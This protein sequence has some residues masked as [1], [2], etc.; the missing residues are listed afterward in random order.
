[1]RVLPLLLMNA[2]LVGLALLAY[3]QLR[4]PA[5]AGGANLDD[6]SALGALEERVVALERS[7]PVELRTDGGMTSLRQRI[8]ALEAGLAPARAAAAV[9]SP[10]TVGRPG[11]APSAVTVARPASEEPTD[12]EVRRFRRLR[13][14]ARARERGDRERERLDK[15][16]AKAGI[17]LA[18]KQREQ[19]L[20]TQRQFAARRTALWSE[21]KRRGAE[22]G[23]DANWPTI[24][25]E[26]NG[27]V[28]R[29]FSTQIAGFLSQADAD[30]VAEAVYPPNSK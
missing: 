23:A 30:A 20:A 8:E 3:D 26:T 7:K 22:E 2:A 4:D 21:A 13:D 18:P 24:I 11:V 17:P 16:L 25:R 27:L 12:E 19:V 5:P 28:R 1:M 6:A 14:A 10:E 29:E 15:A 9:P